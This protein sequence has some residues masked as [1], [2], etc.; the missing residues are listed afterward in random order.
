MQHAAILSNQEMVRAPGVETWRSVRSRNQKIWAWLAG[1]SSPIREIRQGKYTH[2]SPPQSPV[3]TGEERG[4]DPFAD[5]EQGSFGPPTS[6]QDEVAITPVKPFIHTTQG[7]QFSQVDMSPPSSPMQRDRH[8]FSLSHAVDLRSQ[9][10]QDASST[11]GTDSE[12]GGSDDKIRRPGPLAALIR[13]S[14]R[15]HRGSNDRVRPAPSEVS[16]SNNSR[17]SMTRQPP[18]FS[19]RE[20]SSIPRDGSA[21]PVRTKSKFREDLPEL[22][23]SPP[24]SRLQSPEPALPEIPP[25]FSTTQIDTLTETRQV[26]SVDRT[27]LP[28]DSLS[29]TPPLTSHVI[30]QSL[31]SVDSEASWLSGKPSKRTSL[32]LLG[33]PGS[34]TELPESGVPGAPEGEDFRRVKVPLT[35]GPANLSEIR[36]ALATDDDN[37]ASP[38]QIEPLPSE[39]PDQIRSGEVGRLPSVVYH[40]PRIASHQGFR[41]Q[42]SAETEDSTASTPF[43]VQESLD[44]GTPT[45]SFPGEASAEP[46]PVKERSYG[47]QH[48]RSISRGSAVLLD[49]PAKRMSRSASGTPSPGPETVNF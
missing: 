31:A 3:Q 1:P 38:G 25:L 22:P 16:F 17:E 44:L 48:V 41:R 7:S 40:Q 42:S 23:I 32:Q 5:F 26:I 35:S 2:R 11:T 14:L 29:S 28:S 39:S 15:G 13:R 8:P 46:S 9:S 6:I 34:L 24:D 10:R 27:N 43:A 21:T 4:R 18:P 30:P 12:R 37:Q 36:A 49:I 47:I 33:S 19:V 20:K 45:G